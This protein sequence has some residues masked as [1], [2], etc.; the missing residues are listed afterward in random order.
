MHILWLRLKQSLRAPRPVFWGNSVRG[1]HFATVSRGSRRRACL[2]LKFLV[3]PI[4]IPFVF[5]EE[6]A[7]KHVS[8]PSIPQKHHL[9]PEVSE[10]L[11]SRGE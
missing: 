2:F 9:A 1:T 5:L 3:S 11:L 4:A 6:I 7:S 8:N 10:G